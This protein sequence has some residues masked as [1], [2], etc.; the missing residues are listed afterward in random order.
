MCFSWHSSVVLSDTKF[1]IHGGYNGNNAL[2]DT[3]IFDIGERSLT[4][5]HKYTH[6]YNVEARKKPRTHSDVN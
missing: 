6:T 1:L 2:S 3:F 5:L 4:I